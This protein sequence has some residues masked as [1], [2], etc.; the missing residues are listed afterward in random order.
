MDFE[1]LGAELIMGG[2]AEPWLA[3]ENPKEPWPPFKKT[4]SSKK[5]P[6]HFIW[7]GGLKSQ[8]FLQSSALS[9]GGDYVAR[10]ENKSSAMAL[11]L[12]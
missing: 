9:I 1:L 5:R 12:S 7:Y 3:I 10:R 2:N 4:I 11:I 8:R 6:G